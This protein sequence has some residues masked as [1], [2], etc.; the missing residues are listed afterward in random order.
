MDAIP[1]LKNVLFIGEYFSLMTTVSLR[2]E[3]RQPGEENDD[4]FA[5]RMAKSVLEEFYGWDVA[6]VSLEIGVTDD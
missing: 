6:S 1:V 5:V 4:D 2:E 3:L